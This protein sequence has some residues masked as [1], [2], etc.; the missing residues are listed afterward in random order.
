MLAGSAG[1]SVNLTWYNHSTFLIE[2]DTDSGPRNMYIDIGD[3]TDFSGGAP[4]TR[5]ILTTHNHTDHFDLANIAAVDNNSF[6]FAP[7]NFMRHRLRHSV[8]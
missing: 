4:M 8:A 6:F 1:A 7:Q 5:I 2:Y 3:M